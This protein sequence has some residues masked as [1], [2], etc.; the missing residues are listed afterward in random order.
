MQTSQQRLPLSRSYGYILPSSLT[1]VLPR[2]LGF[3]P[4]IPVSVYGTGG[5]SLTRSFSRQCGV[6]SFSSVSGTSTSRL[7]PQ[8]ADLPA[9]HPTRLYR[10]NQSPACLPSCVTPS[11]KQSLPVLEYLP[12]VHLL[13][14]MPR[15]RSRLTL[16]R[17]SLPRNPYAFGGMDSHHSFRYSYQHSHFCEV[18]RSLQNDFSPHRT[19]PYPTTYVV[20]TASVSYFSPGNLRRRVSRP[21]SY[22][23]L[24]KWWLLLSQHPGC[25]RDPT[26]FST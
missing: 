6:S 22:Y 2:T 9:T 1:R 21:V 15:I 4:R 3:S 18:H 17:R 11:L 14:S 8:V 26:S 24:F 16:G 7:R 23:A 20:A 12:V 19:L 5:N 10:N 13:R 25:F